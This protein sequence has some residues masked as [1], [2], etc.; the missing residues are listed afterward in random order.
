MSPKT[1]FNLIR[2]SIY[3]T[4]LLIILGIVFYNAWQ[5]KE[6]N[7]SLVQTEKGDLVV[8]TEKNYQKAEFTLKF[9][10]KIPE[11]LIITL[12]KDFSIF[13]DSPS[14][15][16]YTEEEL[17]EKLFEENDLEYP[18]G[19][20]INYQ[21]KN[22]IV[23]RGH[24]KEILDNNFLK[25]LGIN[26]NNLDKISF[27]KKILSAIDYPLDEKYL[28]ENFPERILFEKNGDFY[29]TGTDS[30]RPVYISNIEDLIEKYNIQ[31]VSNKSQPATGKCYKKSGLFSRIIC[32][33][34]LE[35]NSAGDVYR[36]KAENNNQFT[37]DLKQAELKFFK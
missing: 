34:D 2:I 1:K 30:Y 31:T 7:P 17:Q 35:K 11:N 32:N 3:L 20:I 36:I 19:K 15:A 26:E 4:G 29:L 28:K 10:E 6:A 24:F 12:E 21:N 37:E 14:G 16:I 23:Q 9:T 18:N 33:F 13:L 5:I 22:Y 27:N 25:I 8:F